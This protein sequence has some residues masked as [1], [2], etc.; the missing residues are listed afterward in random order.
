M[1][2]LNKAIQT[3][4]HST[5]ETWDHKPKFI[6]N[7]Y[8]FQDRI[9]GFVR[10]VRISGGKPP[11]LVYYFINNGTRIRYA[12]MTSDFEPKSRRRVIGSFAGRGGF[13]KLDVRFPM[14]GIEAREFDVAIAIKH[15]ARLAFRLKVA[16]RLGAKRSGHAIP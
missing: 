9:V 12:H 13:D 15:N 1:K 7:T 8:I 5:V 11:E 2:K 14:P 10:T 6:K 4:F 3:D 16:M